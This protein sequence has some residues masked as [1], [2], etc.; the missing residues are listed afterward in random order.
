VLPLIDAARVLP[1]ASF[2]AQAV[3]GMALAALCVVAGCGGGGPSQPSP[4]AVSVLVGEVTIHEFVDWTHAWAVFLADGVP[5][6]QARY[7]TILYAPTS[8]TQLGACEVLRG[9][10]CH[11]PCGAQA[12]CQSDDHC[13]PSP[14]RVF[15]DAGPLA[16]MGGNG[17]L[18]PMTMR[19]DPASALYAST[20]SPGPGL[21]FTGGESLE[22][23]LAG[24]SGIPATRSTIVTPA[25][26][27][28]TAPARDPLRVPPNEPLHFAW[29]QGNAEFLEILLVAS[30]NVDATRWT[31]VRCLTDD[32][33]EY[34]MPI[35]VLATLPPAPRTLHLEVTRNSERVIAIGAARGILIHTGSTLG[36]NSTDE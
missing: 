27:Q 29:T 11:V 23:A 6:A 15:V 1:S 28:L 25:P 13:A 17:S 20:P 18:E 9:P 19:F 33:G 16:V 24:G 36:T 7:D 8:T 30:S 3:A 34:D 10:V 22:I 31:S 4:S 32:R 26:V 21:V 5:A 35:A 12:Y 14:T 2:M